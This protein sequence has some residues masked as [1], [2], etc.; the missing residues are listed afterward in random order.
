MP[1]IAEITA[2]DVERVATFL[3]DQPELTDRVSVDGWVRSIVPPWK[4]DAPNHGFMLLDGD[5]IVGAYVALYSE[6][7]VGDRVE[8]LCNLCAWVVK[9]AYRLHSLNLM[10]ALLDQDG[11]TFTDFSPVPTVQR[12]NSRFGFQHIDATMALTIN[13]PWPSRRGSVT[14]DL[15]RIRQ[16]LMG[17]E[18]EAFNDHVDTP[19]PRHVVLTR[20]DDHCYVMYRHQRYKRMPCAAVLYVSNPPLF[21]RMFRQFQSHVLA[22]DGRAATLVELRLA[23]GPIPR[24][25][26]V[27]G[28]PKKMFKSDTMTADQIDYLYS[29]L[30]SLEW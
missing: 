17:D 12:I 15:D 24:S 18:L 8:R 19:A 6:R 5:E 4:V 3:A 20:G 21:R 16:T 28:E 13:V 14:S 27:E 1:R 7:V 23:G 2:S 11:F 22:H 10:K 30:V 25:I 26:T 9:P 29:E